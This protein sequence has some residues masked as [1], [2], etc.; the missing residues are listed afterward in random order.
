MAASMFLSATSALIDKV[1]LKSSNTGQM[2]FWF[3]LF[4]SILYYVILMSVLLVA[5]DRI[6][7]YAVKIPESQISIILPLRK[8]SVLVSAIIGGILF[9]EKNLKAKF[10]SICLLIAGIALIFMSK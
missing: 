10:G 1:A 6:Y 9:K 2:Q 7:Y 8:I 5:S 4:L 3:S